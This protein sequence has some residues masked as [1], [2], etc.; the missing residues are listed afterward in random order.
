VETLSILNP[1]NFPS[2]HK[3]QD[4]HE[5]GAMVFLLRTRAKG[6]EVLLERGNM[7]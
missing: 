3:V 2:H 6:I 7:Y 5:K 4:T 1:A